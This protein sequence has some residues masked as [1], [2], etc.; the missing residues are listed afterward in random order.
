MADHNSRNPD[1]RVANTT[2]SAADL[3]ESLDH[4]GLSEQAVA[5][6]QK[7]TGRE[8][9]TCSL[10][11][12]LLD[13]PEA[14]K[15]KNEWCPHCR[16]GR[17]CQIYDKR[18]DSCRSYSCLWLIHSLFGEEWFP[19]RSKI[20]IDMAPDEQHR[21]VDEEHSVVL[22]RFH[23]DPQYPNR[24]KEE[25]YYSAIK[26]LAL[27]GLRGE[28]LPGGKQCLT[29]VI[30]KSRHTLILP[31][32]EIPTQPGIIL[33]VG[34]NQ[35]ELLPCDTDEKLARV[36]EVLGVMERAGRRAGQAYPEI[37]RQN[38]F[39]LLGVV[40][41]DPEMVALMAKHGRRT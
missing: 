31:H 34:E 8:C 20:V 14:G 16:P 24:W 32:K 27:R 38:P 36:S 12:R 35:F 21:L 26:H 1:D 18:P 7:T 29:H 25:P 30:V 6:G 19:A 17:G 5:A 39:A 40:A 11:C 23:V 4:I 3:S 10:C 2:P 15:A 41:R 13:V 33:R 22:L 37:A 28:L 9:G